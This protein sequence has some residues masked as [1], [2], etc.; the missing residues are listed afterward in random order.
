MLTFEVLNL[1]GIILAYRSVVVFGVSKLYF[2]IGFVSYV[3]Y[4]FEYVTAV[5]MV[6]KCLMFTGGG[7]LAAACGGRVCILAINCVPRSL[8]TEFSRYFKRLEWQGWS[9]PPKAA[10][11]AETQYTEV[12][13]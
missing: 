8:L 12:S 1:S 2:G 3:S 11:S 6:E 9:G 10:V 5:P 13:D 4:L 7:V